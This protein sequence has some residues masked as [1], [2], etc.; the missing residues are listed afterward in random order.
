MVYRPSNPVAIRVFVAEN[1]DLAWAFEPLPTVAAIVLDTAK[2]VGAVLLFT[3]PV[4]WVLAMLLSGHRADAVESLQLGC[5]IAVC[6]G[7]VRATGMLSNKVLQFIL[8]RVQ[9]SRLEQVLDADRLP[10]I[11]WREDWGRLAQHH[12]VTR[13]LALLSPRTDGFFQRF[14]FL[15][16]LLPVGTTVYFRFLYSANHGMGVVIAIIITAALLIAWGALLDA[17]GAPRSLMI[18]AVCA[19]PLQCLSNMFIFRHSGFAVIGGWGL[20]MGIATTI[21]IYRWLR[22]YQRAIKRLGDLEE[23]DL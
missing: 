20:V 12:P 19:L 18:L 2:L 17:L 7:V 23:I 14:L 16:G 6:F 3:L 5:A 8:R 4:L 21:L 13:K 10:Q 1:P 9:H 15:P 11:V 22:H